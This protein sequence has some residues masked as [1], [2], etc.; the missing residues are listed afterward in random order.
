MLEARKECVEKVNK[1]FGRNWTVD[2][3]SAWKKIRKEIAQKE[4]ALEAEAMSKKLDNREIKTVSN[5]LD[6]KG[7]DNNESN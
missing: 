6:D 1:M 2:F 4:E 5:K 7:G 3:S